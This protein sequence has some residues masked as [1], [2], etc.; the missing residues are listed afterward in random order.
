[1][2]FDYLG[3]P[4]TPPEDMDAAY[5]KAGLTQA[6]QLAAQ[7][8]GISLARIEIDD[9]EFPFLVGVTF[10][11]KGDKDKLTEQ[12]RKLP[13]YNFTGGVGGETSYAM[14]LVPYPAFPKDAGRQIY[15]RLMLRETILHDKITGAR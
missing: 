7:T 11:D 1:M 3:N 13:A 12:L 15:H 9:S 2:L 8:A 5:T 10:G 14:N 4:V 6:L